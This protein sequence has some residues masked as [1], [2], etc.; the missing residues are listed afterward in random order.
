VN[1]QFPRRSSASGGKLRRGR[2]DQGAPSRAAVPAARRKAAQSPN[3]T[4]ANQGIARTVRGP[5]WRVAIHLSL[6]TR[7]PEVRD[8]QA[9]GSR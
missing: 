7:S 9:D 6:V 8:E 4:N 2:R 3:F 5:S 1:R